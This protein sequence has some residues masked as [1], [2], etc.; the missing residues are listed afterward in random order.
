MHRLS[1]CLILCS[2]SS[3]DKF[4]TLHFTEWQNCFSEVGS[5]FFDVMFDVYMLKHFQLL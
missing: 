3:V 4:I 5:G 2:S 1:N